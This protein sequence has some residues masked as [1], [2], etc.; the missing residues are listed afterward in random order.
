MDRI[1]GG[2][3]PNNWTIFF[4]FQLNSI[5]QHHPASTRLEPHHPTWQLLML[6][7]IL[8]VGL[9]PEWLTPEEYYRH[10]ISALAVEI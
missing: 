7:M 8:L 1:K 5:R 10:Q 9:S 4:I 3:I 6:P 2:S